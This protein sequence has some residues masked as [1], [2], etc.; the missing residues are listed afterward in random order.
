[1][2]RG[3]PSETAVSSETSDIWSHLDDLDP[4]ALTQLLLSCGAGDVKAFET[5]YRLTSPVIATL[6]AARRLSP[7]TADAVVVEVY[8]SIWR[9]A[10]T[11]STSGCSVWQLTLNILLDALARVEEL[12][13]PD[14][15]S[16]PAA[17]S[18]Q[19]A[20]SDRRRWR[21]RSDQ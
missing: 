2:T 12:K 21:R 9:R 4:A 17:H 19:P 15:G 18:P 20:P 6:V 14:S 5:F 3:V 11:F 1:M 10:P 8:V 16:V 13:Q 7:A